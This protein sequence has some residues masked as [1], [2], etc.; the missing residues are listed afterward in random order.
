MCIFRWGWSGRMFRFSVVALNGGADATV[1]GLCPA[2]CPSCCECPFVW[3]RTPVRNWCTAPSVYGYKHPDWCRCS[4]RFPTAGSGS[5]IGRCP[6]AVTGI[7][8]AGSFEGVLVGHVDDREYY[9]VGVCLV[10]GVLVHERR[11]IFQ[12]FEI[13]V[14]VVLG[15]LARLLRCRNDCF[16]G[17]PVS[18]LVGGAPGLGSFLVKIDNV[19][20]Q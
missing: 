20:R 15:S 3:Y 19:D 6:C 5:R 9:V 13:G 8:F 4:P 16:H 2:A 17:H 1:A 10:T 18:Y 14:D 11:Q 7:S 12:I